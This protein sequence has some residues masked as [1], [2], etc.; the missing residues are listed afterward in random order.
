MTSDETGQTSVVLA[1]LMILM[2]VFI[3]VGNV[4]T[5]LAFVIIRDLRH[6]ARMQDTMHVVN[7]AAAD[8]I[9]GVAVVWEAPLFIPS[10]RTNMDTHELQ[11]LAMNSLFTLGSSTSLMTLM[12][13][14]VDRLLYVGYPSKYNVAV[15]E[16]AIMLNISAS[17]ILSFTGTALITLNYNF[18]RIKRRPLGV[19]SSSGVRMAVLIGIFLVLVFVFGCYI[20]IFAISRRQ[21]RRISLQFSA[22]NDSS[23]PTCTTNTN[24]KLSG[25]KTAALFG[26]RQRRASDDTSLALLL[27]ETTARRASQ[28]IDVLAYRPYFV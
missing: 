9:V 14:A 16:F 3:T 11:C 7:L 12:A 6:S 21:Q 18:D 25:T 4:L 17:W 15:T 28:R 10:T 8:V 23:E 19:L 13:L 22:V 27:A 26:S 20:K 5:I 1:V 2:G 24:S